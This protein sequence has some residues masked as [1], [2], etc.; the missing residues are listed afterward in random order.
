M[1]KDE[2]LRLNGGDVIKVT[3]ENWEVG[4]VAALELR[5]Q[6]VIG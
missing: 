1:L 5:E 6:K 4:K 2:C 3:G